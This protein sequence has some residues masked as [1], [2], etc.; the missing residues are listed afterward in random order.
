MTIK[1]VARF[2]CKQMISSVALDRG[3]HDRRRLL[4]CSWGPQEDYNNLGVHNAILVIYQ[5]QSDYSSNL[6]LTILWKR[7]SWIEK[8]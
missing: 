8:D 5:Q 3:T 7:G 4:K 6:N 1:Y 2:C